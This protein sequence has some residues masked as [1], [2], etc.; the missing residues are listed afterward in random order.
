MAF[1]GGD[2]LCTP[3]TQVRARTPCDLVHSAL[4]EPVK[5]TGKPGGED[6]KKRTK[7]GLRDLGS[8]LALRLP[9]WQIPCKSLTA[10]M[11]WC[12]QLEM[13]TL[14]YISGPQPLY[15]E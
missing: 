6:S 15:G 9:G 13:R 10:L 7:L 12:P 2:L 11:P 1:V 5:V 4:S 3:T 14:G 8:G